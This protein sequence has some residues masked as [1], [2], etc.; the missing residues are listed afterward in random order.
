MEDRLDNWRLIQQLAGIPNEDFM[1][2]L[3]TP[4]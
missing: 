4:V 3:S 2:S 1:K